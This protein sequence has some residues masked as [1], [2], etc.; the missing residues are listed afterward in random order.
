MSENLDQAQLTTRLKQTRP[1]RELAH[2]WYELSV[3]CRRIGAM[4]ERAAKEI[5]Y[6]TT[7]NSS[8]GETNDDNPN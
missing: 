7:N 8:V 2:T 1:L 5:L 6:E 4:I 3:A